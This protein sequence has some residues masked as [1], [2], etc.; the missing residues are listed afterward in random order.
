MKITKVE[1]IRV[2]EFDRVTWVQ[3][4]TDEG[5]VGLG[6]TWY[7]ARAVEEAIH[8]LFAPLLLGRSPTDML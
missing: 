5:Q 4:H 8:E 1:T 2:G 7:G 3:I 6:E